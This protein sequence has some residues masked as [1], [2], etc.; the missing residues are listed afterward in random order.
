MMKVMVIAFFG[1]ACVSLLELLLWSPWGWRTR[2]ATAP[3]LAG[4]LFVFSVWPLVVLWSVW[5]ALLL[6]LSAYRVFNLLRLSKGRMHEAYLRRMTHRTALALISMQLGLIVLWELSRWFS[7][8]FS[9][10][11]M[12]TSVVVLAGVC[13]FAASTERHLRTTRL[14]RLSH[15]LT[16]AE[17][18]TLTVAIPARNETDDLETCLRSL[19]ASNYPKL[20]IVVLDDCSQNRHTP[21]IIRSFA[22]DGVRFVQG[23]EP[24]DTWLA[25]NQAYQRLYEEASGELLLFC[26]VDTR[27]EPTSLRAIVTVLLKKKKSMMSIVPQNVWR[28]RTMSM[29]LVQPMRYTWELALP[30]RLLHRPPVLSTCWITYRSE[31]EKAGTFAAVSR[32]IVPESYFVRQAIKD[33]GYTFVQSNDDMAL[34]SHKNIAEQHNTALRTRYPQL[35]RKPEIVWLLTLVELGLVVAPVVNLLVAITESYAW[36]WIVVNVISIILLMYYYGKVV[37]VTYRKSL[38]LGYLALPGAL[39]YDV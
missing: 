19:I 31:I 4:V 13:V 6:F 24:S 29:L 11:L 8:T 23:T 9:D 28:G 14:P 3:F 30:R 22:H 38:W 15:L 34:M 10:W 1:L 17:L 39:L 12:I 26:G 5:A 33:D 16:D 2:K 20:E 25:K 27:F 21:E 7:I 32:K 18:P 36:G 35:H 37:A